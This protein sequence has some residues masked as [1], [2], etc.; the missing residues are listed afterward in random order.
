MGLFIPKA[1][2]QAR[3]PGMWRLKAAGFSRRRLAP[4]SASTSRTG[5]SAGGL[6]PEAARKQPA[7]PFAGTVLAQRPG[8]PP[9]RVLDEGEEAHVMELVTGVKGAVTEKD[10]WRQAP[11]TG[12]ARAHP[13]CG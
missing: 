8:M 5:H 4:V 3:L 6:M 9:D 10:T 1:Q 7:K 11:Q 2:L 12:F 13:Y